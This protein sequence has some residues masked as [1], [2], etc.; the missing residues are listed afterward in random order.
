MSKT[1]WKEIEKS[2]AALV[3][4]RRFWANA[5][6][7]LD[8]E[9]PKFVGQVKNVKELSMAALEALVLE[10][11]QLGRAHKAHDGTPNPKYGV[12]VTKRSAGAGRKTPHMITIA[13]DTWR[14][15]MAKL[16]EVL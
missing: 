3:D 12:V 7:R 10:V 9:G 6:E 8:F 13:E 4:G 2:A 5:G 1:N 14:E 16:R 11:E 15:I